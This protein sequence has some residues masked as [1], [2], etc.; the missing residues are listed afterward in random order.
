VF[1][2]ARPSQSQAIGERT[3]FVFIVS[4]NPLKGDDNRAALHNPVGGTV[5]ASNQALS[6]HPYTDPNGNKPTNGYLQQAPYSFKTVAAALMYITTNFRLPGN[7]VPNELPWKKPYF[8][9]QPELWIDYIV[10]QCYPGIYGP[11][12]DKNGTLV[13]IDQKSGLPF[14]GE[15]FPL[16]IPGRVSLQGASALD[17]VFDAREHIK[18]IIRIGKNLGTAGVKTYEFTF[19]DSLTI[20]GARCADFVGQRFPNGAGIY[21]AREDN[22]HAVISNCFITDNYVGIAIDND[23]DF[24]NYRHSPIIVNNTISWNRVGIWSGNSLGS[25]K[26]NTLIGY[27]NPRVFNNIMDSGDPYARFAPTPNTAATAPFWGLDPTD[28]RIELSPNVYLNF[29]AFEGARATAVHLQPGFSL[30]H[31]PQTQTRTGYPSVYTARV[32]IQV[33]TKAGLGTAR[34]SLHI[35]DIFR[36]SQ[37]G[38]R[39]PHDFR[40]APLVSTSTAAP[41]SS[42]LN[43]LV[44][45]GID[46]WYSGFL[47]FANQSPQIIREPGLPG[48]GPQSSGAAADF[49]SFHCWDWCTEG[50]ANPR[51]IARP[52]FLWGT[53]SNLDLGADEMDRLIMAGYIDR[54][55]IF[56]QCIPDGSGT[57]GAFL[58]ITPHVEVYFFNL[59]GTYNRPLYTQWTGRNYNWWDFT[60]ST[61]SLPSPVGNYTQGLSGSTRQGL[62]LNSQWED[63]MRNLEC[64]ASPHLLPDYHPA[65]G[66]W[67]NMW[68]GGPLANFSDIFASNPWVQ[69]TTAA[70]MWADNRYLYYDKSVYVLLEGTSNP[71]G[72]WLYVAGWGHVGPG[73]YG[74]FG[75]FGYTGTTQYTVPGNPAWGYGDSTAGG[76]DIIP[77]STWSGVR[78]TNQ[79]DFWPGGTATNVQSFLG[80]NGVCLAGP[81]KSKQGK[82]PKVKLVA[83]PGQKEIEAMRASIAPEIE[84]RKKLGGKKKPDPRKR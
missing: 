21:I 29:N 74:I 1:S 63:F 76:P 57:V 5:W 77:D 25:A 50:H 24:G 19:I 12:K 49:A 72:S 53:Y 78:Y 67:Q 30:P 22:V 73:P 10:I 27:A 3:K 68:G 7:T 37:P 9:G 83:S 18:H 69:H 8:K 79:L 42:Q 13:P 44:N 47:Q 52:G 26:A 32:D 70:S 55:R 80:V 2:T 4:V 38:D 81:G 66:T 62:V 56:S 61:V 48:P 31:W 45:Q 39:S 15:T 41:G 6:H 54:T 14:N 35:N 11:K 75:P 34:G 82:A 51:I 23:E 20:R 17:T 58:P 28:M 64:D 60:Q 59:Q 65:W 43:P 16:D 46:I 71:P 33:Y 40:L 84:R 36:N